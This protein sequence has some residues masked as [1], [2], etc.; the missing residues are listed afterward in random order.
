MFPE[1]DKVKLSVD[2]MIK[3]EPAEGYYLAFSG[4]KDSQ[5]I[6]HIAKDN[7]IKFDAHYQNTTVDPPELIRFIKRNYPDVKFH[8][9]ELSMWKLIEKKLMPPTRMVR[10][11][12]EALKENGGWDRVV[13]TGIRAEESA[14]RQARADII[15]EWK[16]TKKKIKTMFNPIIDWTEMEVWD[17][18]DRNGIEYCELYD[19]GFDRLGCIGCPLIGGARQMKEFGIYPKY[20]KNYIRAFERMINERKRKGKECEWK[21]GQEVMDWWIK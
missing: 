1:T 2:R 17:Y 18:I 6:Y 20:Y 13:M 4:G 7:G 12:C 21:T 5:V 11:C 19:N 3:Y 14:S 8:N 10:Y 16:K 9:P 15:Y